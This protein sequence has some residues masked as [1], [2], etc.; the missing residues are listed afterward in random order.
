MGTVLGSIL[1]PAAD[2]A[3]MSV[4]CLSTHLNHSNTT[5]QLSLALSPTPE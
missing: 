4:F 1:D 5:Q 2:K 3:L